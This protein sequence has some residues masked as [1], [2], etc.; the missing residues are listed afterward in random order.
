MFGPK[1]ISPGAVS[2]GDPAWP[3]T[4]SGPAP[5]T[6]LVATAG[7]HLDELRILVRLLDVDV[8]N[9]VWVTSRNAQ[10]EALL[11]DDDVVWVPPVGSG[12]RLRAASRLP[13]AIRVHRRIRPDRVIS[14]GALFSTPHLVA[15]TL[16]GTPTWFIDSAT[17]IGAPSSTGKFVSRFTHAKLH[18][19][20]D[21]WGDPRWT[22]IPGVFDSFEANPS[23][24]TPPRIRRA[25][26]ALGTEVWPFTRAV[27]RVLE[28]LPDAEITWQ[29]GVTDYVHGRDQLQRWMPPTEL[30]RAMREADVVIAHAGV[31]TVLAALGEGKV[32]VVLPRLAAQRE[33]VDDHQVEG[34]AMLDRRSLAVSVDPDDLTYD[35]LMR[36]ASLEAHERQ[37][38]HRSAAEAS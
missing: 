29:V 3:A 19:Q 35:G 25:V 37:A 2:I 30:R 31:G 22:R 7:G 27:D 26:V 34:A 11:A 38:L 8:R 28:L 21:G 6:L 13:L 15:A 32:P 36:A 18:V 33:H 17:R 4:T 9:A 12:H 14:T 10:S 1:L 23:S 5:R 24:T 20:G 16:A